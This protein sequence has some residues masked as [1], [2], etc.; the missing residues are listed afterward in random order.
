MPALPD[1]RAL[2][3]MVAAGAYETAALA[4]LGS[5][6]GFMLSRGVKGS[7]LATVVLS[8]RDE[9]MTVEGT[10]AALALLAALAMALLAAG[11]RRSTLADVPGRVAGW[12]RQAP[13]LSRA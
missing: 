8:G 7:S 9:E 12:R 13:K 10:T 4:L 1:E 3:A 11:E 5:E 2:E 6:T